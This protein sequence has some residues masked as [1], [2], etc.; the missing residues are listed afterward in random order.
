MNM[1]KLLLSVIL[2]AGFTSPAY[3]HTLS[4]Q[5]GAAALYHQL[6]GMHHLPLTA[7]LIAVGVALYWS[8]RKRTD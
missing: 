6:L 8:S 4:L 2:L 7:L 5:D 3:A 1:K